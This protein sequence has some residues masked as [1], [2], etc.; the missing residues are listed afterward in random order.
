MPT[1]KSKVGLDASRMDPL[2][3]DDGT[4]ASGWVVVDW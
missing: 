4:R 2:Q 1:S 3:M